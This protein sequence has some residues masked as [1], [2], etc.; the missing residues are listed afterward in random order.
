MLQKYTY[1]LTHWKELGW[2]LHDSKRTSKAPW[3]LNTWPEN[4]SLIIYQLIQIN[5]NSVNC[6]QTKFV[7]TI[8]KIGDNNLGQYPSNKPINITP[9]IWY[10]K[11]MLFTCEIIQI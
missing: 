3:T 11:C 7:T 2:L 6:E 10:D 8:Q 9:M 4:R 5:L 1:E